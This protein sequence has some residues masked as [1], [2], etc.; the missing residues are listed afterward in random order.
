MAKSIIFWVGCCLAILFNLTTSNLSADN[1]EES[2]NLK[3]L[4]LVIASDDK[5]AYLELQKIWK[6]YM[7]LDPKHFDVYFIRGNPNLDRN[8]LVKKDNIYTKSEESYKPGILIKSVIAMEAMLPKLKDYHYVIRTNLSSF[9]VFPRLLE[10]LQQLPRTNCYA[11]LPLHLPEDW[12]PKFG[13]IPFG[14]GAGFIISKDLA[15]M[16]LRNKREIFEYG[17]ELPDDVA[18]GLFFYRRNIPIFNAPRVDLQTLQDWNK[19]KQNIPKEDF[20]F[21][22]K[23][24]YGVREANEGYA[25]EIFIL[26]ELLRTFYNKSYQPLLEDRLH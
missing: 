18:F 10:F 24:S 14:S 16:L 5:P 21:R 25:D 12:V 2:P 17:S 9:Y 22:A 6:A 4:V 15:E 13:Y 11:S 1:I 23:L 26:S 3:T 20:H 19:Y 7:N 8:Y